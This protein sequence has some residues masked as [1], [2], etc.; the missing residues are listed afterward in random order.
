M[1]RSRSTDSTQRRIYDVIQ[2]LS[3]QSRIL[4]IPR[5]FVDFT[6]SLDTALFLSQVIYWSDKGNQEGWFFKTYPDWEAETTL[7]EYQIRKASNKLKE[8]KILETTIKKASGNPTV[9]Y[10]LNIDSFSE[11]F[12]KF[13]KKRNLKNS[14][15]IYTLDDKIKNIK[16][17]PGTLVH[18]FSD[19][20]PDN[21]NQ[22]VFTPALR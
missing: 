2:S 18:M 8:M 4:S 12:L 13:L 3:G 16:Q 21:D 22:D 14:R 10:K 9:H 20:Y 19:Q 11:S 15:D 1:K 5:I 7:S 6:G 17:K